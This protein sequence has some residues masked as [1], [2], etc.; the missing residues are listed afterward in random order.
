MIGS[1]D[2][3]VPSGRKTAAE[4]L[5]K[6]VFLPIRAEMNDGKAELGMLQ[7]LIPPGSTTIDVGANVG[8][9]TRRL[10][11]LSK[12]GLVIAFEP[13]SMPRTVLSVTAFIR[14]RANII[15]L[16]FALG[17]PGQSAARLVELKVPIKSNRNIGVGLAH[18][19]DETDLACR[20]QIKRELVALYALDEIMAHI[21]CPRVSLIK[22]DVEGGELDVLRGAAGTL[23]THKPAILCE[24]DNREGRFGIGKDE[25]ADFLRGLGYV[26]RRISD[27][28]ELPWTAL[29][30]NTVFTLND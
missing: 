18:I 4:K 29:D 10:A 19:G 14:R 26:P 9:F 23:A 24:I 16:P 15:V 12:G 6:A 1:S 30:K 25:L 27:L 20:F 2:S 17:A 21:D 3:L 28:S 13:Q 8:E 7:S 11:A 22:I 5:F